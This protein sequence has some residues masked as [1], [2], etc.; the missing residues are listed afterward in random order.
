M[1]H[2]EEG[3]VAHLFVEDDNNGDVEVQ[4]APLTNAGIVS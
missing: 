2:E 3:E 4:Q 1:L